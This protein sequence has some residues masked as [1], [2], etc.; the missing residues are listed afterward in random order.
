[1]MDI[2]KERAFAGKV[3]FVAGGSGGINLA[4]AQRFSQLGAKV[5]LI[6]RKQE[7]VQNAAATIVDSGGMAMGI[8][9]DVRNYEAVDAAMRRVRQE[10][11]ELDVVIS[12]AAG[13]F[14]APVLGMSANAFKTVIDIDLL[15][16]FN[17]LRACYA[18]I[19]KPGGSII[20]I[21]AGQAVRPTM[22]QAH[23]GA[24][25]AGVNNLTQTLAMEWGPAGIRI[26]AIAPGPIG[27][28][29][30]M[31]RLAPSAELTAALKAKIPLRDYGRK[32]DI[33]DMAVFLCSDNAR[34]VTGAIFDCDGGSVLGDASA[35]ALTV[36]P[37]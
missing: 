31:A 26:N 22:F 30:G 25:K 2:F 13:N 28:T 27:D 21:T 6:S 7:R 4:I 35:D 37:R 10:Y 11:G 23:A 36:P 34:Y 5:G 1:M 8:E 33:A 9:A 3:A 12:G 29:E 14:L 17:V 24:A 19:R 18:H 16:T 32:Q 15:G 20:S